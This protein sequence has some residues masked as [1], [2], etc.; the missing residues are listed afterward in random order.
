MKK[1]VSLALALVLV[2]AMG[3][4]AF[5]ADNGIQGG[6]TTEVKYTVSETYVVTIPSAVVF[7]GTT[8]TGTGDVSASNVVLVNG[9]K[10]VVKM[11]SANGFN[12][13]NEDSAIAYTVKVGDSQTALS[14]SDAVEV[15]AVTCTNMEVASDTA[16][17]N[18]ATTT[19]AIGAATAA[20]DHTD[21]LTF[22]CEVA[23][24]E[25]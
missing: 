18:F 8:L 12:L 5:A 1:V 10:L 4:P 7:T 17:L 24:V 19:A 25:E 9:H 20:G 16:T 2:L 21:T 11:A 14:G 15:L 3:I 13:K 6:N 23:D 22:S